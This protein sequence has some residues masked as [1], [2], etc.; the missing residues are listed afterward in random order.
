MKEL[1]K[2][3]LEKGVL[4]VTVLRALNRRE[5]SMFMGGGMNGSTKSSS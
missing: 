5:V 3:M 4:R 1:A 2:C